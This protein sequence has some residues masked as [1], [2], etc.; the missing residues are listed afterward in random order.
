MEEQAFKCGILHPYCLPSRNGG[1]G[2]NTGVQ[3]AMK[4]QASWT[5]PSAYHPAQAL[6]PIRTF[7]GHNSTQ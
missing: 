3:K 6:L 5:N 1:P 7:H 4:K 2:G